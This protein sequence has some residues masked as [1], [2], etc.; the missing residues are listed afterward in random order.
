MTPETRKW[1]R[2]RLLMSQFAVWL[3]GLGTR[4]AIAQ[5]NIIFKQHSTCECDPPVRAAVLRATSQGLVTKS[6]I[7]RWLRYLHVHEKDGK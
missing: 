1:L 4:L 7:M 2:E 6:D 3:A 5:A